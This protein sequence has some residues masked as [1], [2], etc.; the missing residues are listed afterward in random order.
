[1]LSD[2]LPLPALLIVA[3][4]LGSIPF[5]LLLTRLFT[6]TDVREVG[7]G[8]IGA[9]NVTRVA[10]PLP[11]LLTLA[12]DAAKGGFAVLL[13]AHYSNHDAASM[14]LAADAALV[15]HCYPVWLRFKGGKGVATGLGVFTALAPLAGLSALAVF[16]I[17]ALTWR[18]S[19]L[20][21]SLRPHRCQSLFTFCGRRGMR[22]RWSLFSVLSL[23]RRS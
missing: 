18:F 10:G 13:A 4:L 20:A 14:M 19:S 6:K 9:A 17:V 8:N 3:Y 11:G 2:S 1:M 12:F 7:S 23:P 15:G 5:G 21:L 22:R 16:I